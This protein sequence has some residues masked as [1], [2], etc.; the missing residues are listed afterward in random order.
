MPDT[1]IDCVWC[2][3]R[4]GDRYMCDP[5]RNHVAAIKQ[6][7]DANTLP[8]MSFDEPVYVPP[9]ADDQVMSQLVVLAGEMEVA[10]I[11]R[12]TLVFTGRDDHDKPL[13]RWIYAGTPNDIRKARQ[14]VD[15]MAALAL[16]RVGAAR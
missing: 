10:G 11:M 16:R 7:A 4:H 15:D 3:G 12:P 5:V 2:D 6:R 9:A 8:T 1:M 14:L 13:P